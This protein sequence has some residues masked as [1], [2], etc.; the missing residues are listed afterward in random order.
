MKSKET[1]LFTGMYW[2]YPP[3][4][5]H[6]GLHEEV[7]PERGTFFRFQLYEM[8]GNSPGEGYFRNFWVGMCRWDPGTLE[9]STYTIEL[10]QLNFATL[11]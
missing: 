2:G 9:P 1:A 8:I 3:P 5:P 7:L 6:S 4:P 10:V 11:Y